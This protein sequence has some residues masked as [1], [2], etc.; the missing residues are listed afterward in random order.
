MAAAAGYDVLKNAATLTWEDGELIAV[1]FTVAFLS[2]LVVVRG[3]VN[4]VGKHGFAPF[5]YYRIIAGTLA[6]IA[7]LA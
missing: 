6:L 7:L 3:F 2:A 5:A 1:G 4:F